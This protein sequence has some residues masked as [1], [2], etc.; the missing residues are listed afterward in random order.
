MT[1]DEKDRIKA[2][3]EVMVGENDRAR[4][5]ALAL[6]AVEDLEEEKAE[7]NAEYKARM[8]TLLQSA[9]KLRREILTGQQRLPLE[10]P[11]QKPNGAEKGFQ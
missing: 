7:W 6:Q 3:L 5:L 11:E 10:P 4:L 8:E 9:R 1:P 2:T